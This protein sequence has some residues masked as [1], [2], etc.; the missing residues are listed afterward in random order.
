MQIRYVRSHALEKLQFPFPRY[1]LKIEYFEDLRWS[2]KNSISWV[3]TSKRTAKHSLK[4]VKDT[5][6][7]LLRHF[8]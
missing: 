4:L 5:R 2:A 7:L 8:Y 1:F 6:F 3:L